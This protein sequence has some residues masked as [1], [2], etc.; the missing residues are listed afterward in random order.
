[1]SSLVMSK[2][3]REAFLA[4]VHVGVICIERE[5]RAPLSAPIWYGYEPGGEVWIVTERSSLKGRAIGA[6][7]RFSLVAQTE[8]PPYK[9][10]SVEG[11]VVSTEPS[12]VER[13][14]R[15]LAHRY[16]G[17]EF[18]DRYIEATGGADQRGDNV[19]IRMRPQCWLSTDYGKQF[20]E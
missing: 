17:P 12:K 16:L 19:L 9:Y 6:A 13:D 14:V 5:G 18:G 7:G 4:D 8:Q 20:S 1:M 15:P 10:V 3:E 11:D 2:D